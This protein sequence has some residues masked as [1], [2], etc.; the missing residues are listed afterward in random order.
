MNHFQE[1]VNILCTGHTGTIFKVEVIAKK[2]NVD[3]GDGHTSLEE[4]Q[5]YHIIQHHFTNVGIQ[6][7]KIEGTGIS[8]LNLSRSDLSG[9][10][11]ENCP[12]LT[13]LDCSVNELH[14]LDLSHCPQLEELYCN[15]NHLKRLSF[16]ATLHLCQLNSAYNRLEELD[17]SFCPDLRSLQCS[18]NPLRK[19]KL[20]YHALLSEFN[21]GQNLLDQEQL[22]LLKNYFSQI[23]Q[24]VLFYYF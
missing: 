6:N 18:N 20:G 22:D 2:I 11:L 23:G 10:E 1:K 19:C 8:Y 16:A 24:L 15:S 4:K 5:G 7:I 17:I 13:Y 12:E 9:L 21:I 3:W 14:T